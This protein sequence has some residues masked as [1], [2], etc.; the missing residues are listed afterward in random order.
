MCADKLFQNCNVTFT[1]DRLSHEKRAVNASAAYRN[2]S[3]NFKRMQWFLFTEMRIF[4]T[5]KSAVLFI[6]E[7]IQVEI[8]FMCESCAVN[9]KSFIINH[10]EN[11]V[12]KVKPLSHSFYGYDLMTLDFVW[13]YP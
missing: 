5:S 11:L 12:R 3:S 8:C 2:P 7:S 13:K 1:R 6:H 4:G 9:I 10:C